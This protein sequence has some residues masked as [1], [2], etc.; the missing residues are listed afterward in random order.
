MFFPDTLSFCDHIM[1]SCGHNTL[2]F[3]LIQNLKTYLRTKWTDNYCLLIQIDARRK[4]SLQLSGYE[5]DR[6]SGDEI[7]ELESPLVKFPDGQVPILTQT[8]V[9]TN[10]HQAAF[11]PSTET[12]SFY[13]YL[14]FWNYSFKKKNPGALDGFLHI[15]TSVQCIE[16]DSSCRVFAHASH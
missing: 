13:A 14:L 10:N 4:Q 3:V 8:P 2:Q 1:V 5:E 12:G 16:L 6:E 15:E 9:V 11:I 7:G